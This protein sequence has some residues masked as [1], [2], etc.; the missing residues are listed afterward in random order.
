MT[1]WYAAGKRDA[2]DGIPKHGAPSD[3][4]AAAEWLRGWTEVREEET[5]ATYSLA[6][7]RLVLMDGR[8][9]LTDA[10]GRILG[11]QVYVSVETAE[12]GHNAT[13]VFSGLEIET[14]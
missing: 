13:V 7:V 3:P 6:P 1:D 12:H 5:E 2:L 8:L 10:Q 14:G 11:A 9:H 4:K